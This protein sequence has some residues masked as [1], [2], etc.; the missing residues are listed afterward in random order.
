MYTYSSWLG[1]WLYRPLDDCCFSCIAGTLETL[2]QFTSPAMVFRRKTN[3]NTSLRPPHVAGRCWSCS[4]TL[5]SEPNSSVETDLYTLPGGVAN[6]SPGCDCASAGQHP[7]IWEE[8]SS[9]SG[10]GGAEMGG[11]PCGRPRCSPRGGR[12]Q[13]PPPSPTPLPPLR[14]STPP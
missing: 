3:G 2:A 4:H 11:G 13:G 9:R 8:I 14:S 10:G 1:A 5:Y 6:H 7:S 12:P